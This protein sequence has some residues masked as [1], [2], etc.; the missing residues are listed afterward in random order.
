MTDG[1]VKWFDARKGYGF[2]IGEEGEDV[3]VHYTS[4]VGDGFR[5]LKDGEPVHYESVR[6]DKGLQARN[7]IRIGE[8]QDSPS[9]SASV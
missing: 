8:T 6:G 3:F 4:I 1:K 5:T 7:V 9:P 2:I